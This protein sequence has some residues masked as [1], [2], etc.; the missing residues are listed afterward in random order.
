MVYKKTIGTKSG[1][2][3]YFRAFIPDVRGLEGVV[4]LFEISTL[5]TPQKTCFSPQGVQCTGVNGR[6]LLLVGYYGCLYQFNMAGKF[7][8]IAGKYGGI[9]WECTAQK[10]TAYFNP[11]HT[12][13]CI[14]RVDVPL[15]T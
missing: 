6:V 13:W 2:F 14:L 9:A 11:W 1:S 10:C 15:L 7:T 12:Y 3:S 4:G 8:S 5:E